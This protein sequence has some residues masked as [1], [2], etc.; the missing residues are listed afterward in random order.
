VAVAC[1]V[2]FCFLFFCFFVLCRFH[3]N[4]GKSHPKSTIF[5]IFEKG[6]KKTCLTMHTYVADSHGLFFFVEGEEK[7]KCC[8]EGVVDCYVFGTAGF[9]HAGKKLQITNLDTFHIIVLRQ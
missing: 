9:E 2:D 1:C 3:L 5:Q 6:R 8:F 7:K 4:N